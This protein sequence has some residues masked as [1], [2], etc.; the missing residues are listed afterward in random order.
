M[1]ISPRT[2][3]ILTVVGML[4][5][6]VVVAVVIV[7]P[8]YRAVGAMDAKITAA[9]EDVSLQRTRLAQREEIKNRASQTNA[10]WLRLANEVP[11]GTDLPSLMIE[12]QDLAFST[13][14]QL[15]S[16][17][18][19]PPLAKDGTYFSIP[20]KVT[21]IGTWSD[22]VEFLQRLNKL[23]RGLRTITVKTTLFTT[24]SSSEAA[25]GTAA[26]PALPNYAVTSDVDIEAY[27]IPAVATPA[28]TP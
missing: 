7:W 10:R 27:L 5:L 15:T 28:K 23:S 20:I 14:V 2:Q 3:F 9:N 22:S 25:A 13:G 24:G 11:E 19:S 17:I 21:V 4:L 18:P 6:L 16:I 12:L 1:R 8:Q 26:N